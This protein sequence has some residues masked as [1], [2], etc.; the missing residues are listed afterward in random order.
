MAKHE[1]YE[2]KTEQLLKPI[3]DANNLE[4][5]DVEFVKEAGS[6]YLRIYIDKHTE[7][8][9]GVTIDDCELVSRAIDEKLDEANFIAEAYILEVSS[10]GLGR[11]LKKDKHFAHSIGE[12]VEVHLFKPI[13]KIRDYTGIL[14]DFNEETITIELE[15]GECQVFERSQI[16][17]VRLTFDF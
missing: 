17:L 5:Y 10:P 13:N 16:A 1:E 3:T 9:D 6:W 8:C 15:S 14:T 2:A 11:Q 4:I 12:E 7:D